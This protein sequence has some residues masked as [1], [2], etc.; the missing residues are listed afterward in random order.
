MKPDE[1]GATKIRSAYFVAWVYR[2]GLVFPL[3]YPEELGRDEVAVEMPDGKIY[4]DHYAIGTYDHVED[5]ALAY[6]KALSEFDAENPQ[7]T[8]TKR[9]SRERVRPTVRR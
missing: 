7:L 3:T 9:P 4:C 1:P 8:K 5:A 6:D 2:D